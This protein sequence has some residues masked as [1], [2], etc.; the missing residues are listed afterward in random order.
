LLYHTKQG[1]QR[2]FT[3]GR[4][5]A[6]WTPDSALDEVR[7]ILG[8]V[9][10]GVEPA[11]DKQ[12]ARKAHTVPELCDMFRE[13]CRRRQA[14]F[15]NVN[16]NRLATLRVMNTRLVTRKCLRVSSVTYKI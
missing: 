14:R 1:R 16:E 2:S 10:A 6:P 15:S 9:T 7:R 4:H 12:T 13:G 8:E 3:I 11:A 5:G